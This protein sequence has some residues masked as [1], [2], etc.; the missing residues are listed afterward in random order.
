VPACARA[1][2]RAAGAAAGGVAG[3]A[4]AVA[5][6]DPHRAGEPDRGQQREAAHDRSRDGAEGVHGVEARQ[7]LAHALTAE[8]ADQ[9]RQRGAHERRR[10]QQQ[11]EQDREAREREAGAVRAERAVERADHR[12]DAVQHRKR[13]Q[14]QH[15]HA[16]LEPRVGARAL[17]AARERGAE[18]PRAEREPAEERGDHRRHGVQGVTEQVGELLRP[19]HLVQQ[20]G[21]ARDEEA[22]RRPRGQRRRAERGGLACGAGRARRLADRGHE[23]P[24][25]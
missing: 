23:G 20:A 13:R 6:G 1:P 17:A 14:P 15:A 10:R 12:V 5:R 21:G 7:L 11:D 16:A 3:A 25:W 22:Q 9:H 19:H 8:V 18:E 2:G 4:P 24:R